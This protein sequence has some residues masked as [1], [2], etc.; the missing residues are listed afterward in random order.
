MITSDECTNGIEEDVYVI[1]FK[2]CDTRIVDPKCMYVENATNQPFHIVLFSSLAFFLTTA[3]G[4]RRTT[5]WTMR[6]GIRTEAASKYPSCPPNS[7][8]DAVKQN[9]CQQRLRAVA[10]PIWSCSV[11]PVLV[12][13]G[14]VIRGD[15]L[16]NRLICS[17][18][19][20]A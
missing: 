7:V 16:L 17:R 1:M 9:C 5:D 18:C 13:W 11:P 14:R 12:H 15:P 10:C 8:A 6:S 2:M 20:V 3:V 4:E 19:T